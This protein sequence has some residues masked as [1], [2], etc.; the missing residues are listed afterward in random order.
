MPPPNAGRDH[1]AANAAL[2]ALRA[3]N[4]RLKTELGRLA[5]RAAPP[6]NEHVTSWSRS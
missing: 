6:A 2:A 3:E 5:R 4:D 1:R